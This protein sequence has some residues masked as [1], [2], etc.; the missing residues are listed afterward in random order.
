MKQTILSGVIILFTCVTLNAQELA[1]KGKVIN[2]KGTALHSDLVDLEGY[3]KRQIIDAI[4]NQSKVKDDEVV[5][6]DS[7]IN[8][9]EANPINLPNAYYGDNSIKIPNHYDPEKD[10]SIRLPNA[11]LKGIDKKKTIIKLTP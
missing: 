9:K 2:K 5:I 6:V 8:K 11:N 1:V 10:I 7:A 4:L 3:E